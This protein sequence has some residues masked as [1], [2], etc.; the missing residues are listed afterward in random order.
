VALGHRILPPAARLGAWPVTPVI[1]AD[2]DAKAAEAFSGDNEVCGPA[3]GFFQDGSGRFA[4]VV[5]ASC[6]T[7]FRRWSQQ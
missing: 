2:I 3:T 6:G 5:P 1:V 7:R 4:G